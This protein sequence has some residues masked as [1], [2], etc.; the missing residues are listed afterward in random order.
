MPS[1]FIKDDLRASVE[2]ATGG[3]VTVLYTA[4]GQPSYMSVIPKFR[5]EDID[6]SL[7]TGVHPA[8]VVGGVEKTELF[9]GT[10][11]GIIKNSEF[12]SLPGVDP[13]VSR[14]IDGFI[15]LA[16]SNGAGWHLMHNA[17]FAAL[18]LWCWRNGYTPRGNTHY[19]RST[20]AAWETARR[21]DGGTPGETSGS[22]RTL[23]GSGPVSWRHDN[24]SSGISDLSGNVWELSPGVRT[25]QGEIQVIPNGDAALSTTSFGETST[26]WKA[27]DGATGLLVTPSFTGSIANGDYVP[28]T[29][30][31]VRYASSGSANYSLV[32]E[33][34]LSFDGISNAG[35]TPV[36]AA[37]LA[38]LKRYGLF[39]IGSGL[40]GDGF[41]SDATGERIAM[42]GGCWNNFGQA[43][44]YSIYIA[45]L[46]NASG[47]NM[48]ARPAFVL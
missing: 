6:A 3:R 43:G 2:A 40:N 1:I 4:T 41:W 8:F 14:N 42:R 11:P 44:I 20:D 16:R 27:I 33:S 9:I 36:S 32:R 29:Q 10:Y 25:V 7:G 5:C 22:A 34:S 21:V 35:A 19:G 45:H 31:S 30:N 39:P 37:A 18:T 28:T 24:T 12:L 17:E 23:T 47:L 46:R 15:D 38:V 13:T 26:A 48:G